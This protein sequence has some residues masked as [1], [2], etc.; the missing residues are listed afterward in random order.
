[1]KKIA[2]TLAIVLGLS[3]TTFADGGGLFQRGANPE[4]QNGVFGNRTEQT[5]P[6][7]PN[8]GLTGNQDADQVPM[9]TGIAVLAALGGAYLVAKKRRE[10]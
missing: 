9:G 8:H 2:L 4:E 1:M 10:E 3:M 6:L 7:L 5:T